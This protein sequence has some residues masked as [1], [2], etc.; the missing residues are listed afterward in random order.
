[1]PIEDNSIKIL[2]DSF[3]K[4][5]YYLQSILHINKIDIIFEFYESHEFNNYL[6]NIKSPEG[7]T[8][9]ES[10]YLF[11]KNINYLNN[12]IIKYCLIHEINAIIFKMINIC[13]STHLKIKIIKFNHLFNN[14]WTIINY[15]K[16]CNYFFQFKKNL[17]MNQSSIKL[18]YASTNKK[19]TCAKINNN[20]ENYLDKYFNEREIID[21]TMENILKNIGFIL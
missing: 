19:Y 2:I 10:F 5:F 11:I 3:P 7:I 20:I 18:L 12:S 4:T 1:M 6:E 14:Y 17:N 15:P 21:S 9:E 13:E 16:N 8:I